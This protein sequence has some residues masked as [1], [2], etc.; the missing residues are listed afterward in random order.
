MRAPK[1]AQSG[2]IPVM[3]VSRMERRRQFASV[4]LRIMPRTRDGT[5]IDQPLY[6]V[7]FQDV[8][9]LLCRARGMPNSHDD[10]RC[11]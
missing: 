9:E 7:C 3:K 11:W 2:H 5:H 4:E 1:A 10:Q 6:L 8:D